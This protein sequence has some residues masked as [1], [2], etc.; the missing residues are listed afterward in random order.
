MGKG[1]AAQRRGRCGASKISLLQQEEE[2]KRGRS[3]STD[4]LP[5][6]R[7]VSFRK[8]GGK[9]RSA[10]ENHR[11]GV[12]PDSEPKREPKGKYFPF[13]KGSLKT[14][15]MRPKRRGDSPADVA[16]KN[17]TVIIEKGHFDSNVYSGRKESLPTQRRGRLR[18]GKQVSSTSRWEAGGI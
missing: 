1:T 7:K 11:R 13:A 8:V 15:R 9:P 16:Q 2:K 10:N 17:L 5:E 6:E 3:R 14:R 4:L 12:P 18:S